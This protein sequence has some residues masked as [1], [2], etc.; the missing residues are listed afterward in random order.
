MLQVTDLADAAWLAFEAQSKRAV[1]G[2]RRPLKE[3]G[4]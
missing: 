2:L 4:S 1:E 3:E